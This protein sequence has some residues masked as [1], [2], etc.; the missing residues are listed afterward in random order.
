MFIADRVAEQQAKDFQIEKQK[1]A[2]E[3]IAEYASKHNLPIIDTRS[4]VTHVLDVKDT[5][6]TAHDRVAAAIA[7]LNASRR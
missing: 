5:P 4:D 3:K 1:Y 6:K 7:G 2:D